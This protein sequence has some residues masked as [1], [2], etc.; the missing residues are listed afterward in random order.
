MCT[1]AVLC[2]PRRWDALYDE[3]AVKWESATLRGCA[4]M[5]TGLAQL[6]PRH[7]PPGE[8]EA[9]FITRYK[10][11]SS[12]PASWQELLL[13]L[14][15]AAG[16]EPGEVLQL[17]P[18]LS[19]LL[20]QLGRAWGLQEPQQQGGLAAVLAEVDAQVEAAAAAAV[21]Y[22]GAAGDTAGTGAASAAAVRQADGRQAIGQPL[23]ADVEPTSA[24]AVLL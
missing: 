3:C 6:G 14:R 16:L 7:L 19:N 21:A 12:R 4:L 20:L 8:W 23:Q 22:G 2:W 11:V 10:A 1:G 9:A 18:W 17:T 24:T 5:A 15:L 13:G